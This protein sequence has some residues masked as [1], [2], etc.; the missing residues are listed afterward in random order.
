MIVRILKGRVN[1]GQTAIFRAQARSV[2][3]DLRRLEGSVHAEVARQVHADG[4]EE[5]VFVSV[6]RDLEAIYGWLGVTDLLDTPMP[7]RAEPNVFERFEVQHY[8]VLEFDE[9]V[10]IAPEELGSMAGE[11]PRA[12]AVGFDS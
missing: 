10:S 12:A 3:P 1:P 2:V 4:G 6:W 9:P 11:P 7:D 5:I 8:E